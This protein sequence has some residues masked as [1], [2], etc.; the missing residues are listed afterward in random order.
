MNNYT[1][2]GIKGNDHLIIINNLKKEITLM[3]EKLKICQSQLT[4]LTQKYKNCL[5]LNQILKEK[6]NEF[7]KQILKNNQEDEELYDI[8]D[9]LRKQVKKLSNKLTLSEEKQKK[10][11]KENQILHEENEKL[12]NEILKLKQGNDLLISKV[13][14]IKNSESLE[15][16]NKNKY[17]NLF[18]KSHNRNYSDNMNKTKQ[19]IESTNDY[20]ENSLKTI[21]NNFK[22]IKIN[23]KNINNDN[24]NIETNDKTFSPKSNITDDKKDVNKTINSYQSKEIIFDNE[25]KENNKIVEQN[26]D[27]LI[28]NSNRLTKKE[29][30]INPKSSLILY[31]KKHIPNINISLRKEN[32]LKNNIT[33][34]SITDISFDDSLNKKTIFEKKVPLNSLRKNLIRDNSR[35]RSIIN[36]NYSQEKY[37]TIQTQNKLINNENIYSY[38]NDNDFGIYRIDTKS[39][40][41]IFFNI[42]TH[43]FEL[44][45]FVNYNNYSFLQKSTNK[46]FITYTNKSGFY[47]LT[48]N[49]FKQDNNFFYLNPSKHFLKKL[50]NPQSYHK[51]SLLISYL[52][53]NENNDE[54][55]NNNIICF[56]GSNTT[57]VEV[58]NESKKKWSFLPYLDN[59]YCDCSILIIDQFKLYCFFGYDYINKCYNK[60]IIWIDLKNPKKWNI[61]NVN[62]EIKNQFSFIPKYFQTQNKNTFFILGGIFSNNI[63]NSDMIQI[64]INDEKSEVYS[65]YNEGNMNNEPFIFNETFINYFDQKNNIEYKCGFDK[66]GNVHFIDITNVKHRIFDYKKEKV[67]YK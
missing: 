15:L 12:K 27:T 20:Y 31:S 64:I 26:N 65:N 43:K 11:K 51:N 29:E 14:H 34:L 50:P 67:I 17:M 44:E 39:N 3:K 37:L 24:Y 16:K 10:I 61:I 30:N 54:K 60:N 23:F 19:N 59:A 55:N 49:E 63:P 62:L 46:N 36:I 53:D 35:N 4:T 56:S 8:M 66:K 41:I 9:S 58:F 48:E 38:L 6:Y 52:L 57:S 45:Q 18:I 33:N 22:K 1:F 21:V 5:N 7:S 28:N 42:I 47:I 40:K 2:L 13:H 25:I 32:N